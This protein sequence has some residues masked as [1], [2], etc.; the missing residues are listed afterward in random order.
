MEGMIRRGGRE[1]GKEEVGE[2]GEVGGEMDANGEGDEEG[3]AE[4]EH[5]VPAQVPSGHPHRHEQNHA[6]CE[7][8]HL[9][10][11]HHREGRINRSHRLLP[12]LPSDRAAPH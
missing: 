10:R 1:G 7:H 9:R 5:L 6:R 3:A 11:A 2:R 8:T 12:C 4:E